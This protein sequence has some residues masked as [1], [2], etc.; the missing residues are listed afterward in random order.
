[1]PRLC[2]YISAQARQ[3]N[4]YT[5]VCKLTTLNHLKLKGKITARYLRVEMFLRLALRSSHE[6]P[7]Q[8]ETL[9]RRLL[10]IRR[11]GVTHFITGRSD[12]GW[13]PSIVV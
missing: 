7:F 12:I 13:V 11:L 9:N 4:L 3:N 10:I 6:L 5:F 1:M 8:H 2:E